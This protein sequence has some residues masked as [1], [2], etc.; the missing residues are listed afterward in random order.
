MDENGKTCGQTAMERLCRE[1]AECVVER[2]P[3]AWCRNHGINDGAPWSLVPEPRHQRRRTVEP[4]Q[5][6]RPRRHRAPH[7]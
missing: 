3:A 1:M 5:G 2:L 4:V 6:P 7:R